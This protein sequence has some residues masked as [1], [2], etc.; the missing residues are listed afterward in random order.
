MSSNDASKIAI[1]AGKDLVRLAL[2]ELVYQPLFC[3]LIPFRIIASTDTVTKWNNVIASVTAAFC[4]WY[5]M[6]LRQCMPQSNRTITDSTSIVPVRQALLPVFICKCGWQVC[7]SR[8]S[9]MPRNLCKHYPSRSISGFGDICLIFVGMITPKFPLPLL[10]FCGIARISIQFQLLHTFWVVGTILPHIGSASLRVIQ[11]PFLH[12]IF[13]INKMARTATRSYAGF[14]LWIGLEIFRSC[15]EH[16][17]AI[18]TAFS[19]GIHS[20]SHMLTH[21]MMSADGVSIRRSVI[22]LAD[23]LIIP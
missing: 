14:I 8:S 6:I 13:M 5:P 23:M 4:K 10:A 21:K 18:F 22:S 3:I 19:R 2:A 1:H 12:V 9:T 16:L 11:T 20:T 7:F 15:G 17:S